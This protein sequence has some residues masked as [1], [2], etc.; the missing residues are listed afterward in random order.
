MS[1]FQGPRC[2]TC[3]FF[4]VDETDQKGYCR[5]YPATPLMVG[6]EKGPNGELKVHTQSAFPVMLPSGWCGE[7]QT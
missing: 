7:H 2:E 6:V 5:R 1:D 4:F 3:R